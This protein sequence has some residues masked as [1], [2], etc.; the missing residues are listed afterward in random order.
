MNINKKTLWKRAARAMKK[1]R[2][3]EHL[4]NTVELAKRDPEYARSQTEVLINY[5]LSEVIDNF[6]PPSEVTP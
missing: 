1:V 6:D 5:V 4:R 2:Y 3:E